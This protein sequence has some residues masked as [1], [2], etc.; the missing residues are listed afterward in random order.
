MVFVNAFKQRAVKLAPV[1]SLSTT[2]DDAMLTFFPRISTADA[3][4]QHQRLLAESAA[5]AAAANAPRTVVPLHPGRP[6]KVLDAHRILTAA[7][8]VTECDAECDE[9]APEE[10]DAKRAKYNNWFASPLI[11]DILAAYKMNDH[12]AKKTVSYLQRTY[13]RLSTERE[14][15]FAQLHEST[16]R[17]W[18]DADGQLVEKHRRLLEE[19][20]NLHRGP[21]RTAVLEDHLEIEKEA[22]RILTAMRERGAVVNVLIIRLVFRALFDTHPQQLLMKLSSSWCKLWWRKWREEDWIRRSFR[23]EEEVD[24]KNWRKWWRMKATESQMMRRM[25]WI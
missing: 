10:G 15:R 8:A 6:R 18:F 16:I 21:G 12:S 19:Q 24:R 17:H 25:C 9:S 4:A 7:A 13:S 22:T 5:A 3:Q 1:Q 14:A 20:K 2:S 23:F 11:H